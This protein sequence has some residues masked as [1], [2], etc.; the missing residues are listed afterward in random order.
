MGQ[1]NTQN[2]QKINMQI[3]CLNLFILCFSIVVIWEGGFLF[4]RKPKEACFKILFSHA[5][6]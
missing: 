5:V 3:G 6:H 4:E 2:K 1:K